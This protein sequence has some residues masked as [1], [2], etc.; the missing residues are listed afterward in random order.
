MKRE[1]LEKSPPGSLAYNKIVSSIEKMEFA[2]KELEE[3]SFGFLRGG[4]I[5][6][7]GASSLDAFSIKNSILDYLTALTEGMSLD[8]EFHGISMENYNNLDLNSSSTPQR[9]KTR[10]KPH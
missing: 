2:C 10:P 9:T 6:D 4:L 5:D 1:V 7:L 3:D 8:M